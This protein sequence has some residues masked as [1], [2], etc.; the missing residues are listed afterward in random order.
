M[1]V[2]HVVCILEDSTTFVN[3]RL[4]LPTFK[5]GSIIDKRPISRC[6]LT[7]GRP[8][9]S[10][11][12]LCF[13]SLHHQPPTPVNPPTLFHCLPSLLNPLAAK[14]QFSFIV[15]QPTPSPQPHCP[16]DSEAICSSCSFASSQMTQA[17]FFKA[18]LL[19]CDLQGVRA[20]GS[21]G[22]AT[23]SEE[24]SLTC[25]DREKGKVEQDDGVR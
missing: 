6:I 20:I 23:G 16:N 25:F 13:L 1:L 2:R 10:F 9:P 21:S 5:A 3:S 22:L 4:V 14:S 24:S 19:S 7:K 17:Q 12:T 8:N 11:L 15:P 18:E